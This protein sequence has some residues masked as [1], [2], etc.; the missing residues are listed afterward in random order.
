MKQKIFLYKGQGIGPE[1][2]ESLRAFFNLFEDI[3]EYSFIDALEEIHEIHESIYMLCGPLED[4]HFIQEMLV[5]SEKATTLSIIPLEPSK[6]RK[7][8]SARILVLPFSKVNTRISASYLSD[9]MKNAFSAEDT[10]VFVHQYKE[11]PEKW[12]QYM[13]GWATL[14]FAS[15]EPPLE[16][17]NVYSFIKQGVYETRSQIVTSNEIEQILSGIYTSVNHSQN[18]AYRLIKTEKRIISLPMHGHAPDIQGMGIANPYALVMAFLGLLKEMG[19]VERSQKA[20]NQIERMFHLL[21]EQTTPDQGGVLNT[22][23]YIAMM[24][25]CINL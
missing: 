5:H 13:K 3:V 1:L 4:D 6:R 9:Q 14:S 20:E 16:D 7:A 19:Y 11:Y 12:M 22:E 15:A 25:E 2:F 17:W 10:I 21:S 18:R 23:K 24:I 8:S